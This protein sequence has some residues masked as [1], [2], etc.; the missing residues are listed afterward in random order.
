MSTWRAVVAIVGVVIVVLGCNKA[1]TVAP[2]APARELPPLA[3]KGVELGSSPESFIAEMGPHA[4]CNQE[5]TLCAVH[6]KNAEAACDGVA[7]EDSCKKGVAESF[8]YG[9]TKATK[10]GFR[11]EQGRAVV[12]LATFENKNFDGLV[13]ALVTKYGPPAQEQ[14][15]TVSNA[16]GAK[17]RNRQLHWSLPGGSIRADERQASI[18]EGA[19][20]IYTQEGKAALGED[21]ESSK[22]SNVGKL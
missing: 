10:F 18:F 7:D 19:V 9:P 17:F 11:Y 16:M 21:V 14:V 13:D 15:D 12:G 5:R 8:A 22:K 3:I 20:S 1:P 6:L 2:A 4:V